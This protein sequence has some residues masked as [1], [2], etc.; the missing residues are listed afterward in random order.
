MMKSVIQV[1]TAQ[2]ISQVIMAYTEPKA[3][4]YVCHHTIYNKKLS[5]SSE[6]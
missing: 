2:T 5:D 1:K 6:Q 3:S 4:F